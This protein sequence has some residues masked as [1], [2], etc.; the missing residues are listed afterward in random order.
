[1]FDF[2]GGQ[3]TAF[4]FTFAGSLLASWLKIPAGG[5]LGAMFVGGGV[6]LLLGKRYKFS[7]KIRFSAQIGLGLVTGGR[8]TAQI[9]GRLGTLLLPILVVTLIMLVGC[10]FLSILLS[11]TTEWNLITCLLCASP[12]GLSVVASMAEDAGA[13]PIITS[14]FHTARI[15]GI[16]V[17]YPL[18]ILPLIHQIRRS[19]NTVLSPTPTA[20]PRR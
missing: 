18:L 3:V 1:M 8:M 15:I 13:D 20:V 11:K 9:I 5:M 7:N 6:A 2:P 16:V 4:C 14:V 12:A 17:I 10:T 19:E